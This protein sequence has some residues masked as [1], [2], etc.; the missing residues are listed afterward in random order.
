MSSMS[1]D[2]LKRLPSTFGKLLTRLRVEQKLTQEALAVAAG[3]PDAT[4]VTTMEQGKRDPTLTELFRIANALRIPHAIFYI[5]VIA[6]WRADPTDYRFYKSRASDFGRLYRLG[7]HHDPGDFRELPRTYGLL[8]Q[9]TGN[10]R[11][12]NAT[13]RSKRLPPIDT[14]LIYVRL[15]NVAIRSDADGRP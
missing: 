1:T 6:A 4:A 7:Y 14:V 9:A 8:D 11:M 12:L 13:R 3:L 10:A 5:D 2:P 15:G